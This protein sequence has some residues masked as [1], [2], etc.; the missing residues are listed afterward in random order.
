MAALRGGDR[1][2]AVSHLARDACFVTPDAT[3]VRGRPDI[4]EILG[5]LTSTGME[6]GVEPLC[7]A[8]VAGN[9]AVSPERWTVSSEAEG[10]ERLVQTFLS[11]SI[12]VRV[13][14]DWKLLILAPWGWS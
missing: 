9:T 14:G 11:R 8:L 2:A 13:E 5:Q 4:A 12:M 7:S 3:V 1:H 6:L 10:G